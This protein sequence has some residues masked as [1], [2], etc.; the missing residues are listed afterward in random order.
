MKFTLSWLKDHLETDAT[1]DTI[2]EALTDLGLEVEDVV[3]PAARLGAFRI[4][5]V[6]EA[7]QHPNADRLRLCRVATY[8]GGPGSAMEEVQVVCGAPNARTG[9]VGVFAPVGTH[10]PGTGVDL[11][12]GNI[13]G[14]D[15]NG[16]LCS[17]RELELSDDH[18]GIIDLPEDAPLGARFIDYRGLNDPMIYIKITPNRPDALGVR[19]IARDLAAR[20]LGKLK[21]Q[22]IAPV[23]GSYPSPIKVK[24][25]DALKEKGCP[26]FAGRLI[27][28]VKNGPSPDW[29]QARLKAIGLRPISVLVDITNFFTFDLNRPLHVFDAAK[30]KGDLRIHAAKGGEEILALDGK[31]YTLKPGMMAISDEN[32]VESI[33]GIMGGEL[34][35]CTEETV[36]V[37]VESAYWDPITIA[38]AGR[39][40]RINSDARYRFE[41]GVDPAFTLPGLELATRMILDLCGGEASETVV[42]GTAP[43]TTRAY[44]FDPARLASLVGLDLPEAGQRAILEDLGFRLD[45]D[46]ATPPSWRPDVLGEADLVEEIARVASLTKLEGKPLPRPRPG[47]PAP[48]LTADQLRERMARRTLAA[49]GYNECVTYS[50]ID[51]ASATLFGGGAEATRLENPISSEMTHMRPD[52]L[53]GL[54]AAAARNQ[55]RGFADLALFE[56]GPAFSGGEPGEQAIQAAGLLIG[57]SAPR[58]PWGSQRPVDL[59]DAK[60]DVEAVLSALG[61]PTRVQIN[62]KVAG[63]WHPGRSGAIA[64]GPNTMA[65]YGEIHPKVLRDLGVKGPAVAFTVW[66]SN[67]PQPKVKTNSRTALTVSDLQ[68]VDRD[69]AFVVPS[70]TEALVIVNAAQ[71]ADKVLI[72][73]VR[74]FDQF[75]GDKATQQ[76]GEGKKSVAITVRLQPTDKTLTDKEIEAVGAKIIEKVTKATGGTLRA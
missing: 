57:Q 63:W 60:A 24:I 75:I 29:L 64:L 42:D 11:K 2:L 8:P 54:L 34:S 12:P 25:E 13:R 65:V 3:D 32:G 28:G 46:M 15:S 41:R 52:L 69:F 50:F 19:G 53:P 14:V 31:T 74:V 44:R 30:V 26:L 68:A 22:D 27:R 49:L 18:N 39:A 45:A 76:L 56:V 72:E 38:T 62:R 16:M 59:F 71:G 33:A 5:K 37:F 7:V 36:D 1:L 21:P 73:S 10:V 20:G 9:L 51:K 47:V 66:P 4:C 43:D 58:D 55:A 17:E 40:L 70:A 23:A 6:I 35:G 67:V 61:A 48:I